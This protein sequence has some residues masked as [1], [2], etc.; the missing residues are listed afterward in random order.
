MKQGQ[1]CHVCGRIGLLVDRLLYVGRDTDHGEGDAAS[2]V[3]QCPR[4][5]RY[6]C[7]AHAEQARSQHDV[8]AGVAWRRGE[9]VL[10]LCPFDVGVPLGD[11]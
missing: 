11:P 8:P 1:R 6:L 5:R 2:I 7:T 4:C 9:A 3:G 10:A